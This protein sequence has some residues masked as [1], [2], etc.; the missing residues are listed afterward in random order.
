MDTLM[1]F[2]ACYRYYCINL[3]F[4]L[5]Y[6]DQSLISSRIGNYI[7]FINVE[8]DITIHTRRRIFHVG[9]GLYI[10]IGSA[11]GKGGL[12]ARLNRYLYGRRRNFWHIDYLLSSPGVRLVMVKCVYNDNPRY[13]E[14]VI[15]RRL[16]E[17]LEFLPNFGSSDSR[18]DLSHLFK[19]RNID[20]VSCLELVEKIISDIGLSVNECFI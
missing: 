6:G 16:N 10:Y 4:Q 8:N 13:Y 5:W 19:C 11:G 12:K 15:S 7:L 2:R 18:G 14:S 3:G 17:A 20:P 9:R 1:R